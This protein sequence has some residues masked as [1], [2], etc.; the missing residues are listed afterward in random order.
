MSRMIELVLVKLRFHKYYNQFL[1]I[2]DHNDNCLY[3]IRLA[4]LRFINELFTMSTT[5]I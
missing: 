2:Q 4:S 5:I 1:Y 3:R